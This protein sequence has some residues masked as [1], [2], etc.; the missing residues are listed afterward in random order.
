MLAA[1][2]ET[3][4]RQQ[5]SRAMLAS[6]QPKVGTGHHDQSPTAAGNQITCQ[7]ITQHLLDKTKL[8]SR[9]RCIIQKLV[10]F[11]FCGAVSACSAIIAQ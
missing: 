11:A 5:E 9:L 8:S 6:L 2:N 10:I 1:A 4:A 7:S 3:Q